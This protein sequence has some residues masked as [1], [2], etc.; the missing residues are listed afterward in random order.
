MIFYLFD[1]QLSTVSKT[2]FLS[3]KD[4]LQALSESSN[5]ERLSSLPLPS[6]EVVDAEQT[7][8]IEGLWER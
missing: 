5:F 1:R 4:Q 7:V 8:V 3:L 6:V 2:Q